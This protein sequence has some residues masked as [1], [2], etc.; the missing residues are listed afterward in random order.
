MK[1][2]M[3][4]RPVLKICEYGPMNEL[5]YPLINVQTDEIAFEKID[6]PKI[7]VDQQIAMSWVFHLFC[8]CAPDEETWGYVD[9]FKN[10]GK[11]DF[12]LKEK[13]IQA[14]GVRYGIDI[15]E[16]KD[17]TGI[18]TGAK[19]VGLLF[20][21]SA[22][23]EVFKVY[24]NHGEVNWSK[25]RYGS[26]SGGYQSGVSWAYSILN[27]KL[28]TEHGFRNP[29]TNLGV[30]DHDLQDKLLRSFALSIGAEI[31]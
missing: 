3:N 12:E 17:S 7:T 28:P 18:N 11:V 29:I 26:L 13:I 2:S 1:P 16:V 31:V 24:E 30:M 21:K 6:Y 27:H 19:I 14:L 4:M 20:E 25:I 10:L 8:D 15:K 22:L 23:A 5:L 9:P